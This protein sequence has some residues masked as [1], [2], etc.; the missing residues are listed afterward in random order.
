MSYDYTVMGCEKDQLGMIAEEVDAVDK[1]ALTYDEYGRPD[2]LDYSKF[3][4]Q[5]IKLCQIQ[6]KQIDELKTEV[7]ELKG[8]VAC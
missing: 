3:V 1:F 6:Q 5:L 7:S 4:P 2:S 8:E